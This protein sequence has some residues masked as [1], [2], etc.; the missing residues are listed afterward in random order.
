MS[1]SHAETRSLN[2]SNCGR[3]FAAQVW[4]IVDAA[5]RP[6]LTG[7]CREGT[8]HVLT[9]P[10]CGGEGQVDAPLLVYQ[11]PAGSEPAGG[12]ARLLFVPPAQTS[13]EEDRDLARA[14]LG[15][16]RQRLG[17]AWDDALLEQLQPVPRQL[18]PVALGGDE[19]GAQHAGP[20]Q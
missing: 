1:Q 17:E 20:L 19:V 2:C 13:S 16:L 6:D 12:S 11:P 18:L 4:L 9:C 8:I 5:E 14:L 3:P 10:H 7:R 15:L